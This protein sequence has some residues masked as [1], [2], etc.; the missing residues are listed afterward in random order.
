M[1]QRIARANGGDT[2]T[3]RDFDYT[4]WQRLR[5]DV[6]EF[7]LSAVPAAGV[8]GRTLAPV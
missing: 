8:V 6:E 7:V 4:D 1:M 5:E 3:S 2:D